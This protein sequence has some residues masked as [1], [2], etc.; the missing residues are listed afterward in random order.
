MPCKPKVIS[1]KTQAA[2]KTTDYN[3]AFEKLAKDYEKYLY[4]CFPTYG[5]SM[6]LL[7]YDGKLSKPTPEFF[8][9]HE[10]DLKEYLDKVTAIPA[11]ELTLDNRIDRGLAINLL[12]LELKELKD[13]PSWKRLPSMYMNEVMY[14]IY[15]VLTRG[16]EKLLDRAD[17]I[18]ARAEGLPKQIALGKKNLDNPPRLFVESAMM[19]ARGVSMFFN[20]TLKQFAEKLDD[21]RKAKLL[22]A[23]DK[24]V[25][26]LE[27][28]I[29]WMETDLLP[30]AKG[31]WKAGKTRFNEKLKLYHEIDFDAD[32]L[33]ELGERIFNDTT[34]AMKKLAKEI[35]PKKKWEEIVAELKKEH[36]TNAQLVGYY[37]KEMDRAKKFVIKNKLVTLPP[38]EEI[39]VV[40]TPDFARPIIPYAAYLMPGLY[41]PEQVGIFWVTTVADGTPK[42][43][44]KAQ[45]EG[46][47]KYGIVVT[48]LH[49][50]YPGHHLQLT[51]ANLKP[52]VFRH[53]HHTSVFA[54]GWALYCEEMMYEKGFYSD[55][56]VRL[57]QLKDQLWRSCRVMIDVSLHTRNMSFDEAVQFL[58]E[59]AHLEHP[60]AVA[61][62]R[63]YCQSPTQPMSYVLGKHLVLELRKKWEKKLGKSFDLKAFHDAF[64]EHGTI[65]IKRVEELME[66]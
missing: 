10:V 16:G 32:S 34:K 60:N 38:K 54:E 11:A 31:E 1:A 55:P 44:A 24:A 30:R 35:D 7:E 26:A 51:R 20:G 12:T 37:A 59:K 14:G 42:E 43:Q 52:R 40:E 49:E 46:H 61:E 33:Y 18:I 66:G 15:V 29:K 47:S 23:C 2:E 56:R 63:R 28:Y 45:L 39:R 57:L 17:G 48:S 25:A 19:S 13:R 5:T 36:P 41:E 62:V 58:V 3:L 8:A 50:A 4:R 22:K 9:K 27:D 64:V 65:P 6:G 53:I 21:A